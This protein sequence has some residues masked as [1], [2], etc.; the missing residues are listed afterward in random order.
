M[1]VQG[2]VAMLACPECGANH[3]HFVFA[4]DTDMAT[5]GLRTAGDREGRCLALFAGADT[6]ASDIFAGVDLRSA[7]LASIVEQTEHRVGE[8]FQSFRQRYVA[9]RLTYRCPWCGSDAAAS[10]QSLTPAEFESG[11][12]KIR[13][14]TG[15]RL[16]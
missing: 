10:T 12:G 5:D 3:P 2:I 1:I 16:A 15:L 13:C 7:E 11:G 6:Q 9:A 4:G 8:S 14:G